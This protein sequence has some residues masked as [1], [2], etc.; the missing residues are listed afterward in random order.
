MKR[1]LQASVIGFAYLVCLAST[2]D[3]ALTI[4]STVGGQPASGADYV[5]FDELALGDTDAFAVNTTNT[6]LVLVEFEPDA[7]VV[8]NAASGLYA[9][10]VLSG[11]NGANFNL[12]PDGTDAT[13]YL[14]T[15]STGSFAGSSITLTF[16]GDQKY[17]GLL[18][19]S[20]DDYN[21]L[22]FFDDLGNSIGV[23][24]GLDVDAFA[25]GDQ[26]ALGTFYV[27]INS[28][29]PFRS[30]VATSSAYAFEFD[31]VAYSANPVPEPTSVVVWSLLALT[32]VGAGW[33]RRQKQAA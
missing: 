8:E 32:F 19:G 18:W 5:T 11:G 14:T 12:Q 21:T 30:V 22:E 13:H 28:T 4:V 29:I 2:S 15:G 9:A 17:L 23:I 20:V 7:K 1:I 31:N 27:N 6:D 24:D 33:W 26:G 10:P 16:S 3:A 25:D